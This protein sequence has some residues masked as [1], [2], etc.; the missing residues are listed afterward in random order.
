MNA[1]LTPFPADSLIFETK[2]QYFFGSIAAK[3]CQEP[4]ET[5]TGTAGVIVR[6]GD[7]IEAETQRLRAL[8]EE[9][10]ERERKARQ[11]GDLLKGIL[12]ALPVGLTVEDAQGQLVLINHA[13]AARLGNA[14]SAPAPTALPS[15]GTPAIRQAGPCPAI[16]PAETEETI[17]GPAGERIWLTARQPVRLLDETMLLSTSFDITE[18][19]QIERELTRRA[20]FDDLTGLPSRMLMQQRVE[21]ALRQKAGGGRFALAFIDLDNFKHINDYYSHASGDALLVKVASRIA[22]RLRSTDMLARMSGDEY[23]LL[24]DPVESEEELRAMI[25]G[26]LDELTRP[27]YIEGFEILTSASIGISIHPQH[28]RSYEAL[29]RNADSAMYGVKRDS[30]GGAAYFDDNAARSVLKRVE[31]EQRLRLAIR[32]RKFCCAFQPKVDIHSRD[33]VGLEMLV[34][35][36]DEDG[37]LQFPS[38]FIGL[39]TEL[40][41]ID[42]ITH[43]V[44]AQAIAAIDQV[45]DAF[46]EDCPISINVAAKQANN[47]KFMYSFVETLEA[48]GHARRF[49]LELTE[50]AF[51]AKGQF[52]SQVLPLL[53]AIGVRVSIDDFGTG[54]SSLSALT[55]ITADEIKIDRSFVTAIHQ[56]PRSQSVLKAIESLA[57]ALG[58]TIVAEGVETFEELAY[59]QAATRI[60]QAQGYYFSKPFFLEDIWHRRR[61]EFNERLIRTPREL[62]ERRLSSAARAPAAWRQ[63]GQ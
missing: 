30:K 18:R 19:K 60:R 12:D 6:D 8:L 61:T 53:R 48:T 29:R 36:R 52:Q 40:G 54:Y 50:D 62:P 13:A 28:G 4:I 17:V 22:R 9:L 10:R 2:S 20:Y 21:E 49:I 44:L 16:K 33:V 63:P 34:R 27:F 23:V 5:A 38:S 32:D 11:S 25:E 41:L 45:N 3:R 46:G 1:S 57:M 24:I 56:R 55:D 15:H 42:Q 14:A 47:L 39:A 7:Q 37:A 51:V 59:L 31:T 26:L 58:M 43:F 35:W